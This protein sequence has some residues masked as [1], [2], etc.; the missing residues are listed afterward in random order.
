MRGGIRAGL[1]ASQ[2]AALRGSDPP[3][4]RPRS[5]KAASRLKV[6]KRSHSRVHSDARKAIAKHKTKG[7]AAENGLLRPTTRPDVDNF[8]KCGLDA[9]N[10]IVW[11]DDSQVVELTVSKFYSSRPRLELEAVEL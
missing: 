2:D 1:H 3:Q 8:C 11:R 5:W 6:R 10:G 9:L 4:S 7:P